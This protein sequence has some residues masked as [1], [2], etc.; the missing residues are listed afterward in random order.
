[1]RLQC[2]KCQNK[3]DYHIRVRKGTHQE[4]TCSSCDQLLQWDQEPASTGQLRFGSP[5]TCK[6]PDLSKPGALVP[7]IRWFSIID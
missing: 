7:L 6:H 5:R 3:F 2:P 4:H 1:M